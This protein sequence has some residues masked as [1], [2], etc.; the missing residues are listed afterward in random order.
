MKQSQPKQAAAQVAA[1]G[2]TR[3][4]TSESGVPHDLYA[5]K[6]QKTV[7]ST[8]TETP[9]AP[10]P[11]KTIKLSGI[12]NSF[13]KL[14]KGPEGNSYLVE[15]VKI[16]DTGEHKNFNE[17]DLHRVWLAMCKRM[18]AKLAGVSARIK[19]LIPRITEFPNVEVVVD[20]ELLLEDIN[21]IKGSIKATLIRDLQNDDI[22]LTLRKAKDEEIGRALTRRELYKEMLDK[23]TAISKLQKLLNLELV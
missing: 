8:S 2:E 15:E 12:A 21:K 4:E 9:K 3:K 18:P 16:E 17:D 22:T 1:A 20:N 7:P 19:N 23:N 14:S 6:P 5:P 13:K 11:R 10:E